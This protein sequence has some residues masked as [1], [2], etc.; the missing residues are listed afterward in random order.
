M[1]LDMDTN[2]RTATVDPILT[3]RLDLIARH[4]T[5]IEA[6]GQQ[7]R[8]VL[9]RTELRLLVGALSTAASGFD[10]DDENDEALLDVLDQ[11]ASRLINAENATYEAGRRTKAPRNFDT[12][13]HGFLRSQRTVAEVDA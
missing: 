11:L 1:S 7:V 9:N 4:G 10:F 3:Q 12:P 8:V 13:H 2:E 5:A 6:A